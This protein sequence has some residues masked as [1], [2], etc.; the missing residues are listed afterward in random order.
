MLLVAA[1]MADKKLNWCTFK[2]KLLLFSPG[3]FTVGFEWC[4]FF[5]KHVGFLRLVTALVD[6][7]RN[8]CYLKSANPNPYTGV[9][10]LLLAY[11][12]PLF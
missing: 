4:L 11:Y 12:A 3:S 10:W 8:V 5:L 7:L 9:A 1:T 2:Q 6:W